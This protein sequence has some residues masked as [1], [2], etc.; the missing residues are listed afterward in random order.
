MGSEGAIE[1]VSKNQRGLSGW[2]LWMSKVIYGV[3]VESKIFKVGLRNLSGLTVFNW[4]LR[5]L[6]GVQGCIRRS[7]WIQ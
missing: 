7:R 3:K 5:V 1:A 4:G 2:I 6:R